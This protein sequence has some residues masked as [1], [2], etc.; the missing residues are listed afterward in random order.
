MVPETLHSKESDQ[1]S[2]FHAVGRAYFCSIKT[3]KTKKMKK[4]QK[5]L[6]ALFIFGSSAVFAQERPMHEVYS[7]M[8]YNFI[9]YVQWPDH[10]EGG[11]F[12]I[13]CSR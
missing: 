5:T 10:T 3:E 8:V 4:I 9:K 12:V 13:W 2:L 11:E 6:L 1:Y 7:M